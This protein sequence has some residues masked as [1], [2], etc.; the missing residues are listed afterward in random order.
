MLGFLAV[1]LSVRTYVFT[2]ASILAELTFHFPVGIVDSSVLG[3]IEAR[4][5]SRCLSVW[6]LVGNGGMGHRDY[7]KG[8]EWGYGS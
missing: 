8:P 3:R 1:G 2:F 6:C 7:Y 4:S 5:F